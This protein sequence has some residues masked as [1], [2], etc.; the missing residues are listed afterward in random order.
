MPTNPPNSNDI[1]SG[2]TINDRQIALFASIGAVVL[3][4]LIIIAI[5]YHK[6]KQFQKIPTLPRLLNTKT[7][8][9]LLA[10]KLVKTDDMIYTCCHIFAPSGDKDGLSCNVGDV[11]FVIE[12][13]GDWARGQN[14]SSGKS[15]WFPLACLVDEDFV[16]PRA[17]SGATTR[18]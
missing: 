18:L 15:G 10:N 5:V 13:T 1:G 2:N 17:R 4:V 9:Y 3:I 14:V 7:S 11:L 8:Q 16:M 12:Y 6:R